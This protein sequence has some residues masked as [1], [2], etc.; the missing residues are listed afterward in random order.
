MPRNAQIDYF[1]DVGE[2][3]AVSL[4]CF[5]YPTHAE[6]LD[7]TYDTSCGLIETKTAL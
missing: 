5:R 1:R 3:F 4:V 2:V 7:L 6:K